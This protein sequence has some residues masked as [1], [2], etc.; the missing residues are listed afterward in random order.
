MKLIKNKIGLLISGALLTLSVSANAEKSSYQV[1]DLYD[2]PAMSEALSGAVSL[3]RMKGGLE[4]NISASGLDANAAY[5]VWWTIFNKPE[6]CYNGAGNCNI[7]D[8]FNPDAMPSLFYATGFVTGGEGMVNVTAR[9][10]DGDLPKG[11]NTLIPGG[12]H[13]GNGFGAEVQIVLRTHGD[14]I[15]GRTAEQIS[16]YYGACEVNTCAETQIAVFSPM[17]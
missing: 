13:D 9:L 7:L 15:P 14:I 10:R 6:N 3:T 8:L 11:T 2:F 12:L 5:T 4:A 16:S 1:A 17:K